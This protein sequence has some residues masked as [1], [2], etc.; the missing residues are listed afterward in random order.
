MYGK[1]MLF[2]ESPQNWEYYAHAQ[3]APGL[4]GAWGRG[5]FTTKPDGIA[6]MPT[7]H[8]CEDDECV[9]GSAISPATVY[10]VELIICTDWN[11]HVQFFLYY[12]RGHCS[13]I[14]YI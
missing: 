5:M 13:I 10:V 7:S 11:F 1:Y 8:D 14:W 2:Y 4:G 9:H 12:F 6:L 3:C